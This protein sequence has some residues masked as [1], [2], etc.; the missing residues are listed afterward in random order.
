[1]SSKKLIVSRLTNGIIKLKHANLPPNIID[2]AKNLIID[3]SG[4]Y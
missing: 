1:M 4:D 2:I 3:I